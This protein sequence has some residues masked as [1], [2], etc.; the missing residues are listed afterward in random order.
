MAV[1]VVG[2]PSYWAVAQRLGMLMKT[3]RTLAATPFLL[4][5][6]GFAWIGIA[7]T[8]AGYLIGGGKYDPLDLFGNSRKYGR[9]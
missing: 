8:R 6:V 1:V 2:M 9:D 3:L 4:I 7:F 5:G